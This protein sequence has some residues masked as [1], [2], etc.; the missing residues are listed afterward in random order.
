MKIL[1]NGPSV[2]LGKDSWTHRLEEKTGFEIVNFSRINAGNKY[3]HDSTILEISQRK[4]DLV[5]ISWTYFA[6]MD[7]RSRWPS[8]I[9][10]AVELEDS[11]VTENTDLDQFWFFVRTDH[12]NTVLDKDESNRYGYFLEKYN[13]LQNQ[14]N[15]FYSEEFRLEETLF[16]SCKI[17]DKD[18]GEVL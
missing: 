13:D 3:I 14:Y 15:H 8:A 1:V 5:I 2:T 12:K 7:V 16:G 9:V 4:Y 10:H 11:H 18:N 6:R 17:L